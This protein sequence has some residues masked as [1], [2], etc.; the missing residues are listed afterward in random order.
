M[1][2]QAVKP[3]GPGRGK[4]GEEEERRK[5]AQRQVGAERGP[6]TG[7]FGG[8]AGKLGGTEE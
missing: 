2:C 6:G 1:R 4:G 3:A 8:L 5:E 7:S